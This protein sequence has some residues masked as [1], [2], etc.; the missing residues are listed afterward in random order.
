MIAAISK[1]AS[2]KTLSCLIIFIAANL[3]LVQS[4]RSE[5]SCQASYAVPADAGDVTITKVKV[6][7]VQ[8]TFGDIYIRL[9]YGTKWKGSRKIKA[10]KKSKFTF[11]VTSGYENGTRRFAFTRKDGKTCYGLYNPPHNYDLCGL[12]DSSHSRTAPTITC[13]P[14]QWRTTLPD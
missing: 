11:H 9:P 2:V 7:T 8:N 12:N 6:S 4:A 3:F 1:G 14:D 10:G 5:C 13:D